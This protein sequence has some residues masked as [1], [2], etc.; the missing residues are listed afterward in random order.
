MNVDFQYTKIPLRFW[1]QIW[2][3]VIPV[4]FITLCIRT[5][6]L[7]QMRVC[8]LE[9]NEKAVSDGRFF[10]ERQVRQKINLCVSW[11]VS[12]SHRPYRE[13]LDRSVIMG[14]CTCV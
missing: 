8:A 14:M 13:C 1:V 12:R 2:T 9:C 6:Y 10:M 3:R 4:L 11:I 7:V 5:L